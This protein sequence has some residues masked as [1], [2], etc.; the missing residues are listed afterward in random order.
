MRRMCSMLRYF[1]W[2]ASQQ[3]LKSSVALLPAHATVLCHHEAG[4]GDTPKSSVLSYSLQRPP[5]PWGRSI[6]CLYSQ[7]GSIM[8]EAQKF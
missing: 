6:V 5:R 8:F 7:M 1:C 3:T 2:T 4:H